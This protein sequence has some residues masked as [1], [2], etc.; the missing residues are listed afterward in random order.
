MTS[1]P[2]HLQQV[3][4]EYSHEGYKPVA[5]CAP[6]HTTY[7]R[8]QDMLEAGLLG[9]CPAHLWPHASHTAA[10]PRPILI[11]KSHQQQLDDL[12][13]ALTAAI[14]D[15]VSR[16]WT[17]DDARFPERMPLDKREEE[18][19]QWL[20]GQVM[21]GNL[22][23]FPACLGSWRPDF[24]VEDN[25]DDTA[26]RENIR[27]TEINA[28]FSFNGFMHQAYGQ[29]ALGVFDMGPTLADATDAEK[30]LDGLFGLFQR[31]LPL[32]L[33]K[34]EENG[35]DIHMFTDAVRRRL[36]VIPTLITPADLRLL[37]GPQSKG[38]LRLCC[39]VNKD[40]EAPANSSLL[41]NDAG[42]VVEEIH[43]VGLELHQRELL[44]L[45]PEMLRQISL[46]CF[47]DMRTILLVHDK[48]MLGIV[49][50]ELQPLVARKVITQMQAKVLERGIVDTILPA[51][52]E[53]DR[54]LQACKLCPELKDAYI[55]KPIRG[56]K[57]AGIVFG[58]EVG[59]EEWQAAL[60]QLRCPG[61]VSA[62]TCV[63]QRLIVPR[64]YHLVLKA[65]GDR[66][67]WPLV[68]TYHVVGGKFLGLGT[69]R[70]SSGRVCAVSTG[71]SWICSVIRED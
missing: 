10:C 39:I 14:T 20:E 37:P 70:S 66:V 12:H 1:N 24:L 23:K 18:L 51:S 38:G 55:L 21:C 26:A 6:E 57:G 36:G 29:Q 59:S 68:G 25:P 41:T 64:R 63:V 53:M 69:W 7:A 56:G 67:Q 13:K 61:D 15:I 17:D 5:H 40:R 8:E 42:E 30:I 65:S 58:D 27:I 32:H 9:R 48:R 35:I 33:L 46:R 19:L 31:D 54:L 71:G 11:T 2:N 50:Q 16:W 45:D 34:G 60:E 44:A 49:K 22:N 3:H 52:D 62:A 4:I 28:R 43:Q 47:N